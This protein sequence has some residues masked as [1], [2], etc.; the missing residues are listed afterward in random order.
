MD[1]NE[2]CKKGTRI[3]IEYRTDKEKTINLLKKIKEKNIKILNKDVYSLASWVGF[4]ID[5]FDP[6][7]EF[8]EVES[9]EYI[10][11]DST[12]DMHIKKGNSYVANG[13]ICHNTINLPSDIE[14]ETVADIYTAA[15]KLGIKG[16]T[17]YRDKSRDGVMV[18][19]DQNSNCDD[20]KKPIQREQ[21]QNINKTHAPKR[22]KDLPCNIHHTSVKGEMYFVI[23]GLLSDEPYEVF[24]GRNGNIKKSSKKGVITKVKRGQYKLTLDNGAEIDSL[25]EHSNED[26]EAVTRMTSTALRHGADIAFIVHQLEKVKGDLQSLAKS[27]ARVLKRYIADGTRITGEVCEECK[28]EGSLVREQGCTKC[29][30]CGWTKCS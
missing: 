14:Q 6:M 1:I 12:Y 10:G 27:T 15:W 8:S 2:I 28:M 18:D 9:I 7:D 25:N 22:P 13:I 21:L 4:K 16:V 20:C 3:P 19:I 17:V 29:S 5:N 23:V 26:E 24:A 11:N 30:N